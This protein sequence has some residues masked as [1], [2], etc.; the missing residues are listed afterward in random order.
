MRIRQLLIG[1]AV[2]SIAA[3]VAT[4][5]IRTFQ[6]PGHEA[7]VVMTGL[8]SEDGRIGAHANRNRQVVLINNVDLSD[9]ES[10]AA[11]DVTSVRA[12]Q[13]GGGTLLRLTVTSNSRTNA[14]NGA[15][16]VAVELVEHPL[17]ANSETKPLDIVALATSAQPTSIPVQEAVAVG[18]V[19]AV[20]GVAFVMV[21]SSQEP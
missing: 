10:T 2:I 11:Y 14:I 13:P 3:G 20:L 8:R 18:A 7:V 12:R 9:L 6:I 1:V 21:T 19:V 15:N 5:G 17:G 4:W 16:A